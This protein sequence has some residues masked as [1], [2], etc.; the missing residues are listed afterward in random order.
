MKQLAKRGLSLLLA[1]LLCTAGGVSALAAEDDAAEDAAAAQ[2]VAETEQPEENEPV[3]LP[4]AEGEPVEIEGEPPFE[5]EEDLPVTLPEQ[6]EETPDAADEEA[7]EEPAQ[8]APAPET[9]NTPSGGTAVQE[10]ADTAPL[11][12]GFFTGA[13]IGSAYDPET[14]EM[15][16]FGENVAWD[17]PCAVRM[18]YI[19]PESPAMTA[20]TVYTF[21]V[22]APMLPSGDFA[23]QTM[24]QGEDGTT[25]L[26]TVATG[27]MQADGAGAIAG[28]LTFSDQTYLTPG[29]EGHFYLHTA[30]D[31]D[32]NDGSGRQ[33]VAIDVDGRIISTAVW[34][35]FAA[36]ETEAGIALIKDASV[37]EYLA[38]RQILWTL[39]VTP[40][41]S[42]IDHI[43]SLVVADPLEE[44][45]L[46]YAAGSARAVTKDGG[47]A[48]GAFAYENGALVFT[49]AGGDLKPDAWPITLTLR[50]EY[51]LSDPAALP[52]DEN[53]ALH[54]SNQADAAV[55]APEY[56]KDENGH[57]VL[58]ESTGAH[59]HEPKTA[60]ALKT[61]SIVYASLTKTGELESGEHVRW[62]VKATNG[63]G[64]AGA[65]L[66]D[67][68]PQHMNLSDG[69]VKLNGAAVTDYTYE[70]NDDGRWVLTVLLSDSTE[71]QT[72]EYETVFD[73]EIDV[74]TVG[75]IVNNVDYYV[76]PGPG[77]AVSK[78][79]RVHIGDALIAKDGV[80]DASTHTV[81]WTIRLETGGRGL[82]DCRLTDRFA[83]TIGG[84]PVKQIY[85]AGSMT[86]GGEPIDPEVDEDGGGFALA[87]PAGREGETLVYQTVLEDSGD[88]RSF[89][90]NNLKKFNIQNTAALEATGLRAKAEIT[91]TVVG[92]SEVLKKANGV[93][94]YTDKRIKW[95]LTA[96]QNKM[97][98]TNGV[99]TDTLSDADWVFDE[100][101][102]VTVTQDGADVTVE[103]P[104]YSK[105]ADSRAVMT[106]RL[107]ETAAG[108]APY[109]VTYYTVPA[110]DGVLLK[111]D[112]V[113]AENTAV[114]TGDQ[115][116]PGGVSSKASAKVGQSVLSKS[117]TGT[118]D[119]NNELT[120]QVDVNRNLAAV[121]A[122]EGQKI[123][124]ADKLQ[125]GLAYVQGSLTVVPLTIAA[126]GAATEGAPLTEGVDYTLDTADRTITVLWA[127]GALDGAYRITFRTLVM[128]SGEYRNSVSF[129]GVTDDP[130]WS[131]SGEVNS[132]ARFSGGYTKL[133]A[134]LGTLVIR[135]TDAVTGGRLSGAKFTV[136][137]RKNG[138]IGE[139][140]TDENGE[141][142]MVLPVDEYEVIETEAPQGY[143]LSAEHSWT[144]SVA[145]RTETV[146]NVVNYKDADVASFRPEVVKRI[147]G[148]RAPGGVTFTFR[149]AAKD[150]APMPEKDEAS[151]TGEGKAEFRQIEYTSEGDYYYTITEENGGAAHFSYDQKP[152][153]LKVT[154]ARDAEGQLTAVGGYDGADTLTITNTY[155]APSN[156]GGGSSGG[157]SSTRPVKPTDPATPV[158][159][160]QPSEPEKP[161]DPT[162]PA[163]PDTLGTGDDNAN[164]TN[165]T[166]GGSEPAKSDGG[167]AA[168]DTAQPTGTSAR[169]IPK[170]GRDLAPYVRLVRALLCA[171]GAIAC[172]W[173]A[174]WLKKEE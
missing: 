3:T 112:V 42:G 145:S 115:I 85:V 127:G 125:D 5:P 7:P 135:K 67:T 151:V 38:E 143:V 172:G 29:T 134:T 105:T 75:E 111:N 2:E 129:V 36:P 94:S 89:W 146:L 11:P 9:Q 34:V 150:G 27:T 169:H 15:E 102:G 62:T 159:P 173:V 10:T 31:K 6:D 23:I 18:D 148:D 100:T 98:L 104:E 76:G 24:V 74:S 12:E 46:H 126:D 119:S 132:S 154:V 170:T 97:R 69:T 122:P 101:A 92:T 71:T 130:H 164:D 165:G 50:T 47:E 124:V 152:H 49:G 153:Q 48:E 53:G 25:A 65:K 91:D 139:F 4:A 163:Q 90:G 21:A 58:E 95:T 8:D 56:V 141:I 43:N 1:M 107:P 116:A 147:D 39:T 26:R 156:G 17:A 118:L 121:R 109:V 77:P 88:G 54:F 171:V 68:L 96:N 166:N 72:L 108:G 64:Q 162:A 14:E 87:I 144:K 140:E 136:A 81:T 84:T 16:P 93:Y 131:H 40:S 28:T 120:W 22:D 82:S 70:K 133:P 106:L 59:P 149:L 44:N 113:T 168:S 157:S 161:S 110:S 80:Y 160:V 45:G 20:G 83:Q 117:L 63:F 32:K 61:A 79:G 13:Q 167:D 57:A 19:V 103:A 55:T 73:G 123:G 114:L 41:V 158:E 99:I 86:L 35:D 174:Y 142:N 137:G 155:S 30:F 33:E 128:V 78:T 51:D 60:A 138:Y 66:V 37:T 52:L